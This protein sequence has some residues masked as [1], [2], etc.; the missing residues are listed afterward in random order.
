MEDSRYRLKFLERKSS[1]RFSNNDLLGICALAGVGLSS[2]SLVAQIFLFV[3]YS[4][5]S[6][7]PVPTLVQLSSGDSI[8]V[9]QLGSKERTPE[10]LMTFTSRALTM[11]MSW[12]GTLP[13]EGQSTQQQEDTGVEIKVEGRQEKVTTPTYQAS[14]ALSEDFRKEFLQELAKLTPEGVFS[15]TT[16]VVFVPLEIQKPIQI[17]PGKWKVS[18]VSNLLV[19]DQSDIAGRA[20]PFNKDVFLQ[21][22]EVPE[23]QPQL[24]GI[25]LAVQQ[26]RS[27]GVEIYAIRDL[28]KED[29]K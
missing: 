8:A 25:A 18:V 26:M 28:V 3:S 20:I 11:L 7:K 9:T 5:L 27:S 15:G 13:G 10:V 14:F 29:L 23:Y 22:V 1:S 21:A 12:S 19:F 16:K 17:E 2:L 6:K 4:S 24:S